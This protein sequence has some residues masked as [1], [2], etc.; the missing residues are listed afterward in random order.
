[1]RDLLVA[2]GGPVGLATALYAVGAG[3]DVV[4]REPREGVID[5]ACGEGLMPSAVAAL[6]RLGVRPDGVPLRGIRYVDGP[7]AAAAAFRSG[8]GRGVARTTLHAALLDAVHR[9]GVTV[10]H[11][12]VDRVLDTGAHVLVDGDPVRY[13]VA[14]D[15]LHSPLRRSLGLDAPARTARRFGLRTHAGVAA[16][17][18][19]VEVHWS[20][21]GEAYVTPV[22][23]G[24][25]GVAV[26]TDRPG[27][28]LDLLP[29][30]PGLWPRLA[31]ATLSRPRGAGPLRQRSRARVRGRVLLVG[32]AA[33]Y[34]DALTGEGI[35]VGLAQ[36][37]AA[38]EAVVAGD[39]ARYERDWRR[40]T[41]RHDVLTH[42]LLAATRHAALRR[43]L[44][45][46]AAA[47]PR[48]FESVVNQ[49]AASA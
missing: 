1:M 28:L 25:V 10:E 20:A 8:P 23:E 49:L 35:G 30:F 34:V 24:R 15:G 5:K 37:R 19:F 42:G 16:W 39:P 43:R 9:A 33:G 44:V 46:A 21:T 26:L 14:A 47:L 32:D 18:P 48:V 36:A 17:S 41:R 13:V 4:V 6:D 11:R 27:R 31:G 29:G 7:H 38:V 45:P 3:L 12:V 40:V 22:A 2:G